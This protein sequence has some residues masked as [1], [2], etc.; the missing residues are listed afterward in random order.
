MNAGGAG[1]QTQSA[2][3]A[4][5]AM[6]SRQQAQRSARR[7]ALEPPSGEPMQGRGLIVA[8][9]VG[10]VT[11]ASTS[12]VAAVGFR[13]APTMFSQE[14]ATA[15]ALGLFGLGCV[16]FVVAIVFG[17]QRSRTATMGIAGWFLLVGSAPRRVRWMLLGSTFTQLV[18]GIATASARPFTTLAFGTLVWVYGLAI[19]GIWGARHG[20]FDP[21]PVTRDPR[22]GAM[23]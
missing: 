14:L 2:A 18:V 8:S 19:C 10:T 7:A 15:V 21:R 11:F 4:R 5:A 22:D 13:N 12:I 6:Q 9:W 1:N 17:A 20:R 3:E 16:G 23:R